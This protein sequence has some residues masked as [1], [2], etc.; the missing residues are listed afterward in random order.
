MNIKI[1]KME[2]LLY[3]YKGH[4]DRVIDGDTVVFSELDLGFNL[5][6]KNPHGRLLGINAPELHAKEADVRFKAEQSKE[7]LASRLTGQDVII[8]SKE[9]DSFGRILC[10]VYLQDEFVNQTILAEGYAVVFE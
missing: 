10:E 1:E 2:D 5:S 8:R 7:Y 4:I 9:V 6:L 3:W